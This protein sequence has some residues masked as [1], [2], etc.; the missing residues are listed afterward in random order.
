[1]SADGEKSGLREALC[2]MT[3]RMNNVFER[4]NLLQGI[5][6]WDAQDA[7]KKEEHMSEHETTSELL[8]ASGIPQ[9]DEPSNRGIAGHF[10]IGEIPEPRPPSPSELVHPPYYPWASEQQLRHFVERCVREAL[11]DLAV[12]MRTHAALRPSRL[13]GGIDEQTTAPTERRE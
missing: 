2:G 1:M 6:L 5:R 4:E 13:A 9:A 12:E 7:D 3:E 10:F 8:H 11:D